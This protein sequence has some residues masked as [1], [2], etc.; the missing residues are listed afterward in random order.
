[1]M[2]DP[3][4][5]RRVV[6]IVGRPNVGKSTIFNR[7]AGR[8]VAIVHEE[9]GVT[10]DR[11]MR[12]VTWNDE[13]FE[14]IDTGGIA[15]IDKA[16]TA[17][18][19]SKGTRMQV[20]A[21][22]ADAAVAILVVDV[23]AGVAPLD[24]EVAR[25][26]R[27][28]GC[29]AFVAANKADSPERDEDCYEFS[30]LG[31]PV[32]P[33]SALHNRGF[34]PL[35]GEVLKVLPK[36]EEQS[37]IFPLK[38]AVV[39]RPNVGKS[40]YIN[41]LLRAERVIVSEVPG[42]TRDSID[43]PFVVGEGPQ[44]RHYKLID[45]AGMRQMGKVDTAVERY[46]HFRAE[47][48]IRESDVSVLVLDAVQGPTL[49]DKKVGAMIRKYEKGCVIVVNKWDLA[50]GLTQREYE[51]AVRK[52]IPFMTHCPIV[53]V[54]AHTGYDIRKSVD[55]IDRVAANV[56]TIL[57][58]GVLNRTLLDT[59]ERVQPPSVGGKRLRIYYVTQVGSAPIRIKMFVNYTKLI[60]E[61]YQQFLL[62]MLRD[63]F[64]LE[65]APIRLEFAAR[66]REAL[67]D[68]LGRRKP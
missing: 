35:A 17:D 65:G 33:V 14:L 2:P 59:T 15:H 50:K 1:M 7:L 11:L 20:E 40:S 28:S 62:R 16:H 61:A 51:P 9:C 43:I 53:F 36:V 38:V 23:T 66:K 21:A 10:R 41:R 46:S 27:E 68:L 37:R 52:E 25:L 31:F 22:L 18:A 13:R 19:I 55:A 45:T 6:A 12:E 54:S 5:R 60:K 67:A 39:G 26:L 29:K 30:R 4:A 57:P 47:D 63:K 8:R 58:T 42:T 49:Q 34:G 48:S 24:V 56:R 44:A 64:G 3:N 32:F